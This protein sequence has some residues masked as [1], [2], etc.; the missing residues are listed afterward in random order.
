MKLSLKEVSF[1]N[2]NMV[3]QKKKKKKATPDQKPEVAEGNSS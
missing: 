1:P 3:F 2:R